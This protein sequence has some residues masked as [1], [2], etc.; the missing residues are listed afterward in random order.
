MLCRIMLCLAVCAAGF[1]DAARSEGAGEAS[2]A[3]PLT[4]QETANVLALLRGIVTD[5]SRPE[6]QRIDA[7]L[8]CGRVLSECQRHAEAIDVSRQ[9]L[10]TPCSPALA[11][12]AMQAACLASLARDG[13]LGDA[14]SL[15]ADWAKGPHWGAA[16]SLLLPIEQ[17]LAGS[18]DVLARQ[19]FPAALKTAA[20]SWVAGPPRALALRLPAADTPAWYARMAFP[21]LKPPK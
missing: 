7:V 19:T 8:A 21:P 2:P 1:A 5:P 15:L 14:R 20:P 16:R 17:G 18:A 9:L 12:A 3:A 4:P 6:A 11:T 13:N 10:Q